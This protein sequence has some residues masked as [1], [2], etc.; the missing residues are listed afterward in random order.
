MA[1]QPAPTP[2][3]QPNAALPPLDANMS[4]NDKHIVQSILTNEMRPDALAWSANMYEAMGYPMAAAALRSRMN[5]LA[6]LLDANMPEDQKQIVRSIV[7][8][9]TRPESLEMAAAMYEAMGYPYAGQALRQRAT[10]LRGGQPPPAADLPDMPVVTYSENSQ[11]TPT[12]EGNRNSVLPMLAIVGA[13]L[14]FT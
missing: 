2:P 9:E 7:L 11:P 8:N 4:E 12:T 3:M 5:A 10:Y 1:Q 13:G 14:A 6:M